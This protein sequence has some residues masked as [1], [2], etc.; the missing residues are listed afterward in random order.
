MWSPKRAAR[1]RM[2][3]PGLRLL[4]RTGL[5]VLW[6]AVLGVGGWGAVEGYRFANPYVQ[7]WLEV[8]EVTVRGLQH[9][10]RDAVLSLLALPP[11]AT[12]FSV[13]GGELS[14]RV[15]RHPWIK[16]ATISR[17]LPHQLVVT[18]LERR[19]IAV[20]RTPAMSLLLDVDG[21]V[22]TVLA[23]GDD[24]GLPVL[25]GVDPHELVKGQAQAR[26]AARA[27][28]RLAGLL[29]HEFDGRP[30]VDLGRPENTVAYVKGFKFQFGPAVAEG[31]AGFEGQWARYQKVTT[32]RAGAED[33]SAGRAGNEIDL[34][35]PGKVI[36]R[37]RG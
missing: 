19:P 30:E 12:Q 34:R 6:A 15:E 37:E 36:V 26:D 22:L 7:D 25:L 11:D 3:W 5:A 10:T 23:A 1:A 32:L 35:Y 2:R 27:G 21:T 33:R 28:I 24:P 18:V 9:V 13:R 4:K 16:Q 14:A 29:S 17:A 20:L 8:R 31:A